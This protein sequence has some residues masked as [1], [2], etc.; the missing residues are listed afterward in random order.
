MR[1]STKTGVAKKLEI[2]KD[3]AVVSRPMVAV[4]PFILVRT[5]DDDALPYVYLAQSKGTHF[6]FAPS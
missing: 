2:P 5:L 4:E 6:L 1:V 3:T